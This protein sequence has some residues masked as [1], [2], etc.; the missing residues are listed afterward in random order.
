MRPVLFLLGSPYY[1]L[2]KILQKKGANIETNSLEATEILQN[3]GLERN[4]TVVSLDVKCFYKTVS[5]KKAKN[6]ALRKL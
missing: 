5:L 1:N 6:K 4:E 2:N 3:I